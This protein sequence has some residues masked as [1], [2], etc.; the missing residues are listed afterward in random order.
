MKI[1]KSTTVALG[2]LVGVTVSS[3]PSSHPNCSMAL[4]RTAT[5]VARFSFAN[6]V[7]LPTNYDFFLDLFFGLWKCDGQVPE[8]NLPRELDSSLGRCA[9]ALRREEFV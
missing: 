8:Q 9:F 2:C 7:T 4:F 3:S 6:P 5:C 1:C